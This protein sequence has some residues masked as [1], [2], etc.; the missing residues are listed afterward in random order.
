MFA[1]VE[2]KRFASI[3]LAAGAASIALLIAGCGGTRQDAHEPSGN[4][5]VS[6]V[7]ASFPRH[8]TIAA[9]TTLS[10]VVRNDDTRSVPNLAVTVTTSSATSGTSGVSKYGSYGAAP[11]GFNYVSTQPGLTNPLRPVWILDNVTI[12]NVPSTGITAYNATW[13]VGPLAAGATRKFVWQLTP[14]K[15]GAW[16]VGYRV[17][18]GLNGKAKTQPRFVGGSFTVDISSKPAQAIVTASGKVKR[19][20]AK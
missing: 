8:Q 5:H 18:A 1:A 16:T 3:E 11:I 17:A 20:T 4:F 12:D 10:L 9:P 14:V 15:T 13:T 6:I 7:K 19:I 2:G